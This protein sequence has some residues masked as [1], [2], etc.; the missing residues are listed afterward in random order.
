MNSSTQ[1]PY[2][3]SL[4]ELLLAASCGAIIVLASLQILIDYTQQ[5]QTLID[6]GLRKEEF[7]RA[8]TFMQMEIRMANKVSTSASDLP[9]D[10]NVNACRGSNYTPFLGLQVSQPSISANP[11]YV[12]YA[13]RNL[14]T[15]ADTPWQGPYAIYRC[16]PVFN[17]DGS[18]GSYSTS[19]VIVT[20][21]ISSTPNSSDPG[22]PQTATTMPSGLAV[23]L[24][25]C[26]N[27]GGRAV[28][29]YLTGIAVDGSRLPT[30]T[31]YAAARSL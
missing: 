20:D 1:R 29:L 2:G 31:A 21:R 9:T 15:S 3:F 17:Q 12:I 24:R 30:M 13:L 16:G 23:G 14:S 6:N 18:Y 22:C 28:Q 7:L 5:D 27:S 19:P 8:I 26:I 25:A 10:S 4:V 11:F